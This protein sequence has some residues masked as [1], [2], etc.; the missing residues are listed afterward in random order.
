MNRIR[1]LVL[2]LGPVPIIGS[3]WALSA[4][5]KSEPRA[6]VMHNSVLPAE[7]GDPAAAASVRRAARAPQALDAEC[8]QLASRLREALGPECHV[9]VRTPF[10]LASDLNSSALEEL[11]DGTIAPAV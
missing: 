5:L 8:E 1:W 2:I 3:S 9:V 4:W 10:V 6:V 7:A 11:H